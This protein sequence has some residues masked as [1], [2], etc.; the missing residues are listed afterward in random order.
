[1]AQTTVQ[2]STTIRFGSAKWEMGADVGSLVNVGAIRNAAWEYR[3][4]KTTVKSDNAGTIREAV[5]NEECGISGDI[6][7]V[8]LSVLGSFYTGVL[9]YDTVAAAPVAVTD[10]AQTLTGTVENILT[11]KNGDDTEVTAITVTNAAGTTT[12]VR[13][14]DYVINVNA[15]GY[16]T[17]ARAYPTVIEGGSALI[18]VTGTDS[19]FLSAGA[20]DAQPAVGD[21]IY[22]TGF[23]DPANNGVKTVTDVS[24]PNT[25]TVAELLVN[26]IEGDTI[27]ITRGGIQS[28]EVVEVD[29]TYTPLASR[30]LKGGGLVTF[31]ARVCRFT[32]TDADGKVFQITIF[33]ATPEGGITM[34]FP[35]DDAEDPMLVPISMTGVPDTSLTAGEQLFE[36]YDEQHV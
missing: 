28:A 17:I 2:E 26:E 31:T 6:M 8:N 18:A 35:A 19:Y 3:F 9:S 36:I 24:T 11:H 7:E 13:D 15:N 22:V 14:C 12:W 1:M 4:D 5:R 27:T 25:I 34:N 10:E 23:T 30:T 20:W 32:N 33:S 29:Y 21:H 16:T